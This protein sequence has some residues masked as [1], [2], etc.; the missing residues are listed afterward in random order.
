M[1]SGTFR[2]LRS[3]SFATWIISSSDGVMSPERPNTSAFSRTTASRIASD[4]CIT[5]RSTTRQL[6]QPST[7]P[8]MFLPMSC[9]SPLTVARTMQLFARWS[10]DGS[11]FSA[12]SFSFSMYGIKCATASFMTRAD[13]IT[14]GK[15][16]LPAPKR[17]PTTDM[18][19]ISGPSIM[20][21]G[22]AYLPPLARA[23]ST[24]STMN[25]GIPLTSAC[26]MRCSTVVFSRHSS[27]AVT[28][29]CPLEVLFNEYSSSCSVASGDRL[30]MASSV[31]L[32]RVGSMSS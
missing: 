6:L 18:P 7:T 16:I 31:S 17:S 4:G 8:T 15:N 29:L 32:R 27:D 9:T 20:C 10:R 2:P 1:S 11:A 24:S 30:R 28:L 23:S 22:R 3:I 19:S 21:R 12:S 5:P 14:C 13:L 25:W 26:T